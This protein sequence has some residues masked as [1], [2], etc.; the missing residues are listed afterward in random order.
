M[1]NEL[2]IKRLTQIIVD[3]ATGIAEVNATEV[4]L[5][6]E[7]A[8]QGPSNSSELQELALSLVALDIGR[9]KDAIAKSVELSVAYAQCHN[10]IKLIDLYDRVKEGKRI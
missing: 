5:L 7:L 1:L 10:L 3:M 6:K 8:V 2:I 9:V 4:T